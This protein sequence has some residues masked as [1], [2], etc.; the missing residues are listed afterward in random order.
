MLLKSFC[1][2]CA[3]T[4]DDNLYMYIEKMHTLNVLH[5]SDLYDGDE[6]DEAWR[7]RSWTA[8]VLLL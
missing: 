4:V 2:R 6:D 8:A 1:S 5:K 7:W 3:F